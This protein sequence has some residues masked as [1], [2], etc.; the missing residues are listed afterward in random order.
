MGVSGN[1]ETQLLN[2]AT[3]VIRGPR[4]SLEKAKP[5][6]HL[7]PFRCWE[8]GDSVTLSKTYSDYGCVYEI[9][10]TETPNELADSIFDF[11]KQIHG[12]GVNFI[13]LGV[14]A[15]LSL[16]F[17]VGDDNQFI[18]SY[19]LSLEV[20]ELLFKCGIAVEYSAYPV[21]DE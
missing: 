5:Q 10:D 15:E 7:S 14:N 16:G 9:A 1:K 12:S 6:V 2:L 3:L 18:A 13:D 20:I 8:A 4:N 17:G 11:L 19:T 21:D